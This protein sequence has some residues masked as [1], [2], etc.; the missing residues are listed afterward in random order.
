[1]DQGKINGSSS[2]QIRIYSEKSAEFADEEIYISCFFL[3]TVIEL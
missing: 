3:T 1:M 2:N